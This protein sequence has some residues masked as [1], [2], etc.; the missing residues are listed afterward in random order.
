MIML[1]IAM[2]FVFGPLRSSAAGKRLFIGVLIGL[3]FFLVNR[4]ISS[5]GLVYGLPP[6]LSAALPPFTFFAAALLAMR[7]AR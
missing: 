6:L 2:P 1:F 3:A 5:F 7:R 4:T